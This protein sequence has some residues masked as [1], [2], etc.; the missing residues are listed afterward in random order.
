[1]QC[2]ILDA[3]SMR[4]VKYNLIVRNM[5]CSS[6]RVLGHDLCII[7]L[8]VSKLS[9]KFVDIYFSFIAILDCRV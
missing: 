1:M 8:V 4:A 9:L 7:P 5:H 2:V 6:Q 3:A